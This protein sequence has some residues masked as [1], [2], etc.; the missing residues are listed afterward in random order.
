MRFEYWNSRDGNWSWHLKSSAGNVV[1]RGSLFTTREHCLSA[2]G[3]VKRAAGSPCRKSPAPIE[4][5]TPPSA[6]SRAQFV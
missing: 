2:I 3:L 5:V 1:V 4:E 6:G